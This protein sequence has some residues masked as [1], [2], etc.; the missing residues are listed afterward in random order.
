MD[1][2]PPGWEQPALRT[3]DVL[4]NDVHLQTVAVSAR[5]RLLS[6]PCVLPSQNTVVRLRIREEGRPLRRENG[7]MRFI[8]GDTIDFR[9]LNLK[10]YEL[11]V[12]AARENVGGLG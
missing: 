8:L 12:E 10:V 9:K 4:V 11:G 6:V 7:A 1:V 5:T 3:L 2:E